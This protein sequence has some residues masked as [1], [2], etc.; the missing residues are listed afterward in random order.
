MATSILDTAVMLNAPQQTSQLSDSTVKALSACAISND[1]ELS[2]R[3]N[4]HKDP[5]LFHQEINLVPKFVSS[6]DQFGLLLVNQSTL[7]V[8]KT[9]KKMLNHLACNEQFLQ[10]L[11]DLHVFFLNPLE[12]KCFDLGSIDL[13]YKWTKLSNMLNHLWLLSLYE[14]TNLVQAS[15]MACTCMLNRRER[16]PWATPQKITTNIR[17]HARF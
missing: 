8:D 1:S 9:F 4:T 11:P 2:N 3:T 6:R 7:W 13:P 10:P 14:A 5:T 17:A 12:G 16:I 15:L